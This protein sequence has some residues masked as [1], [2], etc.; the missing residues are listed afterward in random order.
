MYKK[1][2]NK[3][4]ALKQKLHSSLLV[5]KQLGLFG[6]AVFS[7]P[8]H[9]AGAYA[10]LGG[11]SATVLDSNAFGV[12]ADG[13]VVVG[14]SYNGYGYEA[15][16]WTEAG[17]MVGLGDLPGG[18][19]YSSA[20]GVSADGAVV[21]GYG[22]GNNGYE[23]FRWTE[24]GG[25]VGLGDLLGGIFESFAAGVSANGAV[26]V[27]YGVGNNGYEAFR[28]TEAGG[29]VGLGDLPGG[30]FSSFASGVSANG[31]VVVGSGTSDSGN[32]AFRWTEAGGIVG[33]GDLPGGGFNSYATAVSANGA[34]VVGAG[35]SD[36]G[37]EAF[38]WTQAGGMVSVAGW[39]SAA[40]VALPQGYTLREANGVSADGSVVVGSAQGVDV[41][42]EAF[43]AR[44]S[45][46]G[47]GIINTV[48]YNKSVME[49]GSRAVQAGVGLPA[50]TLFGAHHRSLLDSGLV[51]TAGGACAWATGD[52]ARQNNTDEN[53]GLAELGVCKD[54][55]TARIGLGVGHAWS[56]QDW[57]LGGDAKYDGEYL[58]AE[59]ANAFANGIQPSLTAYYGRFDTTLNRNYQ[60]GANID[61]S[62]GT[63]NA[64]S[65]AV[66]VRVD[67]KDAAQLANV[68]VSPYV[69]YTWMRTNVEGY[70]ETG[71]GFPV[72]YDAHSWDTND[73]RL[74][75]AGLLALNAATD[76]RVGAEAVY[77]SEGSTTGSRGQVL[78]LN[79]FSVSGANINR[80]WGRMIADIDHR[81]SNNTL[82]TVGANAGTSGSEAS[83]GVT[84]GLR[85]NF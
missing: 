74:G 44:V 85:A 43:L 84:A 83:W 14:G 82:I 52:V 61:T 2:L 79:S 64:T 59:A 49:A 40:G 4:S 8:T 21:V 46:I 51:R 25:M 26:V 73:I 29:M 66:R 72:H 71:G 24:A 69:A 70:T 68:S 7:T 78:G 31:A 65:K 19:F 32:E 47:S 37:R 22:I 56:R 17:G 16:R 28:W 45:S 39:L 27:G 34:V 62:R 5:C 30:S 38:R 35:T 41:D 55:D 76:L 81:I 12:S 9:A 48:A 53:M 77:R 10:G 36:S 11:F 67:W 60:N 20:A 63:P 15:F 23:A 57:S 6:L 3:Q 54:L 80:N 13:A 42:S 33:L 1:Y 58:I 18:R 50:L 75:V